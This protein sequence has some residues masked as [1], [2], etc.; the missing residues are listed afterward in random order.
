[1]NA[2]TQ[3]YRYSALQ[4]DGR[5][6]EGIV[7][8]HSIRDAAD[9]LAARGEMPVRIRTLGWLSIFE[10]RV[11]PSRAE[12]AEFLRDLASLYEAG[13]PLRRALEVLSSGGTS[14]PARKLAA[15]MMER[16]DS[17]AD[18]SRATRVGTSDDVV[19]AAELARAG[20]QSGRL[21][22]TLRVG[23]L[24][25]ERQD[26][27]AQRFR[28][29]AAYPLFLMTLSLVAAIALAA[30]AGPALSPLLE[31]ATDEARALRTIVHIGEFLRLHG[32]QLGLA[33][34]SFLV[35][36]TVLSR[37]PPLRQHLAWLKAS[38][39]IIAPIVRDLNCGAFARSLGAL[40]AGGAPAA[41]ALDL[42]ASSA[43]NSTWRR[44]LAQAGDTLRE[45]RTV[46]SALTSI[47]H[48]PGELTHLTRVGEE[49]G[50][51]GEMASRAGDLIL[52]RA[53]RRLDRAAAIAGPAMLVVMGGFIAWMMS[54]FLGGLSSLGDIAL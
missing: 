40:I 45:G 28:S 10:G 46:A 30:F 6:T 34:A 11:T 37:R 13:V 4:V 17:G 1:M 29:A 26:Q 7:E 31:S 18:L 25:L 27:F 51:L 14:G 47:P 20:E 41:R 42:A 2:R 3:R 21:Q 39:P 8:A 43:P 5:E 48:L 38:M 16:L 53:L 54:A 9:H 23:A 44:R 52:E 19:M 22:E 15:L 33:M 36:F 32:A 12:L 50:A 49:T 24:I 35:A